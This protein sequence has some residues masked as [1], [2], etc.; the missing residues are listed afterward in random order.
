[1]SWLAVNRWDKVEVTTAWE[2][3]VFLTPATEPREAGE[4]LPVLRPWWPLSAEMFQMEN[5]IH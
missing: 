5:L 2:R 1:M 3:R 4:R